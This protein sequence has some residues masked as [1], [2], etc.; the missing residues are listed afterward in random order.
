[1]EVYGVGSV[2]V[3]SLAARRNMYRAIIGAMKAYKKPETAAGQRLPVTVGHDLRVV[4]R[5]QFGRG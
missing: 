3:S 2:F 4:Q 1:M 5:T